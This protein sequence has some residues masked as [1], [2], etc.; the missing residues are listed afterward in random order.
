MA[1]ARALAMEPKILILDEASSMLD[2]TSA[3]ELRSLIATLREEGMTILSITH[4]KEEA[5]ASDRLIVMDAGRLIF[6]GKPCEEV[7]DSLFPP[8][9]TKEMLGLTKVRSGSHIL[10][11]EKRRA[12]T[13]LEGLGQDEDIG[14]ESILSLQDVWFSYDQAPQRSKGSGRRGAD[15]NDDEGYVLK[16]VTLEILKGDSIS[17]MGANG[18]GKS[19]LIQHMNGLLRPTSGT[20][21]VGGIETTDKDG[22]NH[23][24]NVCGL[25]FQYPERQIF[26]STVFDEIAFGLTARKAD[27]DEIPERVA[28]AMA[29]VGLD[30]EAFSGRNPFSLSGG[31]ARRVAIASILATEPEVL[32]FD[33]P[34]ASLDAKTHAAFLELL[35]SLIRA[36]RTVVT[37]THD[38]AD[39]RL[40]SNRIVCLKDG[41]I[42][43][44]D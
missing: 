11:R 20:V 22:A 1:I 3:K 6:D 40:L 25:C 9:P 10:E 44:M 19:T 21:A 2:S 7:L 16:G 26:S 17:I 23:A 8:L 42:E 4:S 32:I 35:A 43:E 30:Y 31:E 29:A 34:C 18:S 13:V 15:A 12:E 5:L 24:R 33:E 28:D 36:G 14:S 38:V 37:V 27:K 41:H 39:A